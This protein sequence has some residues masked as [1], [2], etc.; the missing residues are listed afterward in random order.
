[1]CPG[2]ISVLTFP[3][4]CVGG[5]LQCQFDAGGETPVFSSDSFSIEWMRDDTTDDTSFDSADLSFYAASSPL[6]SLNTS[7]DEDNPIH[8][9]ILF[10]ELRICDDSDAGSAKDRASLEASIPGL[11][12]LPGVKPTQTEIVQEPPSES[13]SILRGV[14]R[15]SPLT[16][17]DEGTFSS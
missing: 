10:E 9:I 12:L 11:T 16:L 5:K 7:F 2:G 6:L 14:E 17:K 4:F 1:M 8:L 15:C 13:Q 3:I